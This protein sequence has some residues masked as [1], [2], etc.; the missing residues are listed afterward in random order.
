MMTNQ[1]PMYQQKKKKKSAPNVKRKKWRSSAGIISRG[2]RARA[3][4]MAII[5]SPS[6]IIITT[7]NF[8]TRIH[9]N[10]Y[11]HHYLFLS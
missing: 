6:D 3:A 9:Y 2:A 4:T 8:I 10:Y 1:N 11:Y 5:Q 7:L